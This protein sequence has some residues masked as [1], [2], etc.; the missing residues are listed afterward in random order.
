MNDVCWH[1]SQEALP[2][3][4]LSS[5]P[6]RYLPPLLGRTPEERRVS[7]RTVGAVLALLVPLLLALGCCADAEVRV[8]VTI[9]LTLT[10]T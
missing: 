8:R 7:R 3:Q 2:P 6:G 9:T 4:Q 1:H 10:L 5:V